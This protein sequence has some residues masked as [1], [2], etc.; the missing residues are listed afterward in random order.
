[1]NCPSCQSEAAPGTVFCRECGARLPQEPPPL[2]VLQE[3]YVLTKKLGQGGMG[4]VFLATD[5]RLSTARWAVKELTDVQITSPLER[6]RAAESFRQEA[7]MLAGLSHPNLPR[8]TDSFTQD[9]RNYV[10][11]EFI[12]GESLE[13]YLE[14]AGL[15]RPIPEVMAWARQLCAVLTYLH[16]QQP[17]VI[18]RDLKPGNIIMTPDGTLRLID[19]GIARHFKPGQSRDT[20]AFGTVGYSAPEQYGQ[21]QTDARSDVY[22]LS[23]MLHQMLTGYDP[24]NT[25]FRLP[26]AAQLNRNVPM[27]ISN[28][29]ARGVQNDPAQRF[30]SIADFRQ[31]LFGTGN[32]VQPQQGQV[33]IRPAMGPMINPAG[34]GAIPLQA[35][36]PPPT[37]KS[38][39]L[40]VAAKRLGFVS[41]G[42]MGLGMLMVIVGNTVGGTKHALFNFGSF[43]SVLPLPLGP[44]AILLGLIA[45][46]LK[47]TKQTARG[48]SDASTGIATGILTL[49]LFC[50]L[51]TFIG[52]RL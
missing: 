30:A 1:M 16:T 3:R 27:P 51:L 18:F 11:M 33:A 7:E 5:R 10:V 4:S 19:F 35:T 31:A 47:R 28:V 45:F 50:G 38:T 49:L 2:K 26:P 24:S 6:E 40:A 23:V 43:V 34:A 13:A 29:L 41:V 42:L 8:V 21:G 14:Q 15:P 12:P 48:Q 22:S 32:L 44:L 17:P 52:S 37:R 39:G 20:Q 25:P 36:A 46:F 9:G